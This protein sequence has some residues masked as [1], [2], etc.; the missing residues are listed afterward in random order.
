MIPLTLAVTGSVPLSMRSRTVDRAVVVAAVILLAM[1]T[2]GHVILLALGITLPAFMIAGGILLLLVSIDMSFGRPMT[3]KQKDEET[4][5]GIAAENP[6]V[7]PL[8][9]P[10][11]AGP[12]AMTSVFLLIG[13]AQGN[14]GG[15]A[16]I[17]AAYSAALV[18]TWACMRAATTIAGKV[19]QTGMNAVTRLF[20]IILAA[21]AVQ[22][23]LNGLGE[24]HLFK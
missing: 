13:L 5:D 2:V 19:G 10:I 1:G 11:I 20:A 17:A 9:I 6:A 16:T 14:L 4:R 18:A 22:F 15:F 23:I 8:A 7:F 12:G 24:T 21:L 3:A